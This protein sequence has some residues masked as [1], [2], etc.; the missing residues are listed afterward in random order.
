MGKLITLA[1][2]W[3][4]MAMLLQHWTDTGA[5]YQATGIQAGTPDAIQFQNGMWDAMLLGFPAL[6]I[7]SKFVKWWD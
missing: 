4:I 1:I 6:W 5:L 2:S 3:L 7:L